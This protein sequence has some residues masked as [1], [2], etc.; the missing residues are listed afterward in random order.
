MRLLAFAEAASPTCSKIVA[1]VAR[2]LD[3]GLVDINEFKPEA[4]GQTPADG[5]LPAP[6]GPTR[7][8]LGAGFMTFDAITGMQP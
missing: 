1:M 5:G 4:L 6:M 3:H 7:I 2:A 8:R